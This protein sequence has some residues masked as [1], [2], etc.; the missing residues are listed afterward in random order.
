MEHYLKYIN[1]CRITK[2]HRNTLNN[3]KYEVPKG[4]INKMRNLMPQ[5]LAGLQKQQLHPGEGVEELIE[6]AVRCNRL[7]YKVM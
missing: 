1:I 4:V 7:K 3:S 5:Y 2:I 6:L